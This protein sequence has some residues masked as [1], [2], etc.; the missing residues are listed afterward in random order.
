M[1]C[2]PLLDDKGQLVDVM[3]EHDLLLI[4]CCKVTCDV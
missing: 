3:S 4:P 1:S 2:L